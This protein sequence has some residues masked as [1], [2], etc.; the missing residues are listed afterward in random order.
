MDIKFLLTTAC[1]F[2]IASEVSFANFAIVNMQST[3]ECQD[4]FN[5]LASSDYNT[6]CKWRIAFMNHEFAN[7]DEGQ[8]QNYANA[9]GVYAQIVYC[10]M[11]GAS[12]FN[13]DQGYDKYCGYMGYVYPTGPGQATFTLQNPTCTYKS[14]NEGDNYN[15]A[16]LITPV[17][18]KMNFGAQSNVIFVPANGAPTPAQTATI[19]WTNDGGNN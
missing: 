5:G 13:H 10:S 11:A 12:S 7:V 6:Y 3:T 8:K 14:H 18:C 17:S 1:V 9:S 4:N 2:L 15:F 16:Y 19:K